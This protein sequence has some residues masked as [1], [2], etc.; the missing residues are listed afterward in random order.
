MNTLI[1]FYT[2]TFLGP[3]KFLAYEV[4][5]SFNLTLYFLVTLILGA[6]GIKIDR[7]LEREQRHLT[8]FLFGI[9]QQQMRNFKRQ[10]FV[11]STYFKQFPMII[12]KSI[13]LVK[14]SGYAKMKGIED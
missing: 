4:W 10:K 2:L 5:E 13:L 8:E 7:K 1:L 9:S 14:S 3:F 12:V 6:V 11:S